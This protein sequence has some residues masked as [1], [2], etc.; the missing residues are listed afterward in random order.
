MFYDNLQVIHTRGPLLEEDHY[1]AFGL[2][3]AGI[4][5]NAAGKLENRYKFNGKEIQHQEFS[6]GSGL[7]TYDFGARQYD[8]Q[9]GMW[10]TIDPKADISRRWSTYNYAYDNPIRFIDPDGMN[11]EWVEYKD[12][13]GNK[14]TDWVNEAKD[15]KSAEAWAAK[16]GK[17]G[18]G[19]LKN[20]DV[21]FIGK[22]GTVERG[23][24]DADGKV[25]GYTLNDNG[26]ATKAD[27]TIVGKPATTQSDDANSE[28][29]EALKNTTDA[30]GLVGA[31][32]GL[33]DAAKKAAAKAGE[34]VGE[35]SNL[36]KPVG[37]VTKSLPWVNAGLTLA[38]YEAGNVS[39]GRF[40][41]QE[42]INGI[43]M[44]P[45]PGLMFL[46]VG[47]SIL[48]LSVGDDIEKSIRRHK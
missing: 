29:K 22:T 42:I 16:G 21:K 23:Y 35:V 28:P 39:T 19:H 31:A 11:P 10:H 3:L 25:Q 24:T 6:D 7:E 5:A 14:H 46:S 43:G 32:T 2:R 30:T 45:I 47:L 9:I 40:V 34:V 18:N 48:D 41:V 15:Q 1:G 26:T 27:G 4:S 17:D 36:A 20:T 37:V 33:V 8:Q 44:I 38:N 13:N 12:E